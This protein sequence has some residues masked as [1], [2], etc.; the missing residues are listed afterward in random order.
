MHGGHAKRLTR[1]SPGAHDVSGE[2][3]GHG[4][5]QPD[6]SVE[7]AGHGPGKIRALARRLSPCRPALGQLPRRRRL[8]RLRPVRAGGDDQLPAERPGAQHGRRGAGPQLDGRRR[9]LDLRPASHADGP[10]RRAAPSARAERRAEACARS[11]AGPLAPLAS[12]DFG[13]DHPHRS[14]RRDARRRRRQRPP[15]RL[16]R[17]VRARPG[18]AHSERPQRPWRARNRRAVPD[19][20]HRH[21]RR[22]RTGALPVRT[23]AHPRGAALDREPSPWL[24]RG[25]AGIAAEAG[26]PPCAGAGSAGRSAAKSD[27]RRAGPDPRVRPASAPRTPALARSRRQLRLAV[28]R[29]AQSATAGNQ[30]HPRQGGARAECAAARIRARGFLG[31]G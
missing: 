24:R 10:A 16:G 11:R 18:G 23:W 20:H 14:R 7:G 17:S 13:R 26:E 19:R 5:P 2:H 29:P 31:Q 27:H 4:G 3:L 22:R 25:R 28:D 1:E 12:D 9:R 15:R 21:R 6:G 30:R 8:V